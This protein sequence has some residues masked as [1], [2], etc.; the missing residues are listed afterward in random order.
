MLM[1]YH[2]LIL[3]ERRPQE[4]PL[5]TGSHPLLFEHLI[6]EVNVN[7]LILALNIHHNLSL[8]FQFTPFVNRNYFEIEMIDI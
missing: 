3:N 4:T 5:E 8:A 2:P 7:T 6:I 1:R